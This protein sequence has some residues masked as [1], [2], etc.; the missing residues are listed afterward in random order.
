MITYCVLAKTT[1][2]TIGMCAPTNTTTVKPYFHLHPSGGRRHSRL[3]AGTPAVSGPFEVPPKKE[4][5]SECRKVGLN[6]AEHMRVATRYHHHWIH[7]GFPGGEAARK[8][9]ADG[10]N[11]DEDQEEEWSGFSDA[12]EEGDEEDSEQD[13]E[14][15]EEE[16]NPPG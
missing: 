3:L 13:E 9:L 10:D 8:A 14:D 15:Q 6:S 11:G 7:L 2:P 12:E 1:S 5:C 16:K 4:T